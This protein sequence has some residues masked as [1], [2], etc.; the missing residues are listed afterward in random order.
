MQSLEHYVETH[1]EQNGALMIEQSV[2]FDGMTFL[3][4]I[5]AYFY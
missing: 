4:Y 3:K 1:W 5:I 2:N